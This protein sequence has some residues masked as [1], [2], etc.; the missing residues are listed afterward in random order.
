MNFS[1]FHIHYIFSDCG[2]VLCRWERD[3]SS[4]S[5]HISSPHSCLPSVDS[6]FTSSPLT[7]CS[8]L[9]LLCCPT[10]T[11]T[12]VHSCILHQHHHI[13][14][15][16]FLLSRIIHFSPSSCLSSP[17]PSLLFLPSCFALSGSLSAPE[18]APACSGLYGI[19]YLVHHS[20]KSHLNKCNYI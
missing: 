4:P 6:D 17:S 18:K 10:P 15:V 3:V 14:P 1:H 20:D 11:S 5:Q 13:H 8:I 16:L 19:A 2:R 9:F 7:L 12:H